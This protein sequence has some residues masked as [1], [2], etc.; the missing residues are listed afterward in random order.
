VQ[1]GEET[2][3]ALVMGASPC[4][5]QLSNGLAALGRSHVVVHHP[6]NLIVELRRIDRDLACVLACCCVA[7]DIL[8]AIDDL[9]R[10]EFALT[11]DALTRTA[12]GAAPTPSVR[13]ISCMCTLDEL[14]AALQIS[15][16]PGMRAG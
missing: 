16:P 7:G 4:A 6:L 15:P 13:A 1:I 12:T 8:A 3:L 10:D 14:A 9:V 11:A 2:I 5:R